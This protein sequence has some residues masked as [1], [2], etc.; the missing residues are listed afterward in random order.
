[1]CNNKHGVKI[2]QSFFIFLFSFPC[3]TVLRANLSSNNSRVRAFLAEVCHIPWINSTKIQRCQIRPF[4]L[5]TH[6]KN[7]DKLKI[8]LKNANDL[9]F[10]HSCRTIYIYIYIYM[11]VCVDIYNLL[12]GIFFTLR[13]SKKGYFFY[14]SCI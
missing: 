1:M 11:C 5:V 6:L 7:E 13:S 9:E 3:K 8:I 4:S 14:Y 10:A 2:I 12:Y